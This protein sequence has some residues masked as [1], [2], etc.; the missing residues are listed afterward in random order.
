MMKRLM[1]EFTRISGIVKSWKKIVQEKRRW[2][3]QR[4]KITTCMYIHLL[5]S[6]RFWLDET[7]K[8]WPMI[9]EQHADSWE[10][11]SS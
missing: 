7:L 10:I 3:H 9:T 8:W 11:S 4:K 5:E 1:S 2:R 6:E